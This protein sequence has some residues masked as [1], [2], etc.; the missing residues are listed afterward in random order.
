MRVHLGS[1]HAG[2]ELKDHLIEL[3]ARAGPRAGRPRP[4]RLRRRSTTTRCSACARRRP[5]SPTRAA[6]AS[7]SAGRATASRSPPTRSTGVRAALA[8]SDETAALARQHNDANVLSVGGRMHTLAEMTRFVGVFLRTDFTGEARHVRRIG[9]AGRL[10]DHRRPAAA[11]GLGRRRA[12]P[13]GHTLRRLADDLDRG[14][15][16]AA[17]PASSSPQ[18]RFAADAALLDGETLLGRRLGGQAPVRGVRRRPLRPRPPRADRQVRRASRRPRRPPSARCG[19]GSQNDDVVRRPARRHPVRPGRP[20]RA[21]RRWS[22]RWAPT[23][24]G[25]TPTRRAPG[26]G[27]G[28]ASGR[29][30]TCCWTR[31]SSPGSATS[32]APR[33]SSG[34]GSTRSGRAD[35][36]RSGQFQAMWD[37]LVELMHEGVRTGRI[38]TVRSR[39][40]ARG[41]GTPAARGRP[42][43]R[44]LR[45]PAHRPALPGL[46]R[47]GPHR[48]AGRPKPLLVPALP[49]HVPLAR[50]TLRTTAIGHR[51]RRPWPTVRCPG[52]GSPCAS[53]GRCRSRTARPWSSWCCSPSLD[54]GSL[55]YAELHGLDGAAAPDVHREPVARAAVA[56]VVRRVRR[57]PA[58]ASCWSTSR[59]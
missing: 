32:T 16:R 52:A 8:W 46:R 50:R 30:A 34:T 41:D 31:P 33:C 38:D 29:S 23:R 5:W 9:D 17:G 20:E 55:V 54:R 48:R 45:L 42:R 13:E 11:A 39:A 56:A 24:C 22:P 43:R 36:A 44:G 4:V 2:L 53:G 25:P 58:S 47:D 51:G 19:C 35:A 18:G 26:R 28:A 15:R 40:H 21:R 49:A 7:S 10:R 27:S 12:M 59:P 14:V 1:D 37:D 3:A 6:S 57:A